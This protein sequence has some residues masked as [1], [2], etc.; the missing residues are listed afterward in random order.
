MSV[1]RTPLCSRASADR[2]VLLLELALFLFFSVGGSF[3]GLRQL[4]P[5]C[6][7]SGSTFHRQGDLFCQLEARSLQHSTGTEHADLQRPFWLWRGRLL[8]GGPPGGEAM[9]PLR[10]CQR[11]DSLLRCR[12][13]ST[14]AGLGL[15]SWVWG[16]FPISRPG[17]MG[18]AP[19]L[20]HPTSSRSFSSLFQS[21]SQTPNQAIYG[22]STLPS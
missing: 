7:I 19:F 22:Y 21:A 6:F 9:R 4:Y 15:G 3:F 16:L 10:C 1:I 11:A 18:W 8:A 14:L 12:H 17:P 2:D 20:S 13:A 5:G